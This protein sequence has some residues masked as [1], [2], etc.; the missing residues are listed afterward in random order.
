MKSTPG[1][2]SWPPRSSSGK[3]KRAGE[4][5][6]F[7]PINLFFDPPPPNSL[8]L[9]S[10]VAHRK[11]PHHH[12]HRLN[13]AGHVAL[14]AGGWVR[15]ELLG[16]SSLDIDIAT[17][18]T[19]DKVAAAFEKVVPMPNDTLIVV[20][21]GVPF[22]VT[23]FR[24]GDGGDG[25]GEGGGGGTAAAEAPTKRTAAAAA[26]AAQ[27]E[28]E[29][30]QQ[31][32]PLLPRPDLRGYAAAALDARLRDF[33][34][35]A[36]LCD[37]ASGTVLDWVGG[38]KDLSARLLRCCR[39]TSPENATAADDD[40]G[41][42]RLREDP[43]R[44]LRA[45]RFAA[46]LG[47]TIAPET[48][49]AVRELAP[50][51]LCCPEKEKGGGVA[52]ERI[53]KEL[54][55][56]SDCDRESP[57]AFA[58]GVRLAQELGVLQVILPEAV[59]DSGDGEAGGGGG[60]TPGTTST[61]TTTTTDAALRRLPSECPA[62]LRVATAL[63]DSVVFADRAAASLTLRFRLS[64]KETKL[65]ETLANLRALDESTT[66]V[67]DDDS[68]DD[69]GEREGEEQGA[70][71]PL[72]DDD[73]QEN[74]RQKT[75]EKKEKKKR[76]TMAWVRFYAGEGS[77]SCVAAMAARVS[78]EGQRLRYSTAHS[79]RLERLSR[80]VERARARAPVVSAKYAQ[81][82]HGLKP[83]K[84]MGRLLALAE[85]FAVEQG[86]DDAG[87]VVSLMKEKGLWP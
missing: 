82:E 9:V 76:D 19:P 15:D 62:V 32:S 73:S 28:E 85:E 63:P 69:D 75:E 57:G 29:E 42:E 70:A 7:F 79:K 60:A 24:G 66:A 67:G 56:L 3:R 14:I 74:K 23:P 5:A 64:K 17:S 26:A 86:K 50:L 27:K 80:G 46:G 22:E 72:G 34:V 51:L 16:R 37:P 83:G 45:V 2:S 68:D 41:S 78:D 13:D 21:E 8:L 65:L 77:A 20:H 87:E 59:V 81:A 58:D 38:R 71:P 54:V 44:C 61:S 36:L 33:T 52:A 4:G 11:P 49:A 47:L 1:L 6:Y 31:P 25:G 43:L 30:Q 48:A 53:W 39:S 55:K 10:L 84:E 18:A 12:E 40:D 35:N